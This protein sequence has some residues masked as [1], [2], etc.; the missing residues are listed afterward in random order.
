MKKILLS[1][2]LTLFVSYTAHGEIGVPL[3]LETLREHSA[4]VSEG[5]QG[6][7]TAPSLLDLW[8]FDVEERTANVSEGP[9]PVT[10]QMIDNLDTPIIIPEAVLFKT[11]QQL[12]F[13]NEPRIM[14]IP[15]YA[16]NLT[17]RKT[18]PREFCKQYRE[19]CDRECRIGMGC[20]AALR[21][22]VDNNN[23][24]LKRIQ[25]GV[26][27]ATARC[28]WDEPAQDFTILVADM[29]G[30]GQRKDLI[31]KWI[32]GRNKG[33]GGWIIA[34]INLHAA[35]REC[36]NLG[37]NSNECYNLVRGLCDNQNQAATLYQ[38]LYQRFTHLN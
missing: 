6:A 24:F 36:V 11:L 26:T 34:R 28:N 29:G 19:S 7:S 27:T 22:L 2:F 32:I 30:Y 37:I 25:A 20:S 9:Q 18:T 8:G 4:N 23:H 35:N 5:R 10:S 15:I 3:W 17:L 12:N 13:D 16:L 38:R 21:Q 1:V 33:T 31:S 14:D